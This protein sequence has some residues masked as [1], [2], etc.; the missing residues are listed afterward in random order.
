MLLGVGSGQ[1]DE[2]AYRK[3]LEKKHSK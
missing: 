3:Y 2:V 1:A